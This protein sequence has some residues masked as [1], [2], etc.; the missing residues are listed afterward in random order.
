M[1]KTLLRSLLPAALLAVAVIIGVPTT[2]SAHAV[3]VDSTPRDGARLD[4]LPR[5]VVLRF[6]EPVQIA[7][8]AA[9]VITGSGERVDDG[10]PQL[11]DQGHTVI[12]GLRRDPIGHPASY[13]VSWQVVSADSHPVNG[14]LRFGVGR[15]P[16]PAP[17]GGSGGRSAAIIAG[18][19]TGLGYA[20]LVAALGSLAAGLLLWPSA[21]RSRRLIPLIIGGTAAIVAGGIVELATEAVELESLAAVLSGVGRLLIPRMIIAL[22][23]LPLSLEL[24]T[25]ARNRVRSNGWLLG[26]WGAVAVGLVVII[27]AHGHA[28]TGSDRLLTLVATTGHLIGMS[29][30]LGGLSVLIL[31]VLPRLRAHPAAAGRTI[32]G[33]SRFAFGC[34]AILIISGELLAWRQI[35]PIEALW[36]T[37]FGVILLIKLGL[38]AVALV[39]GR[40]TSRYAGRVRSGARVRLLLGV[41]VATTVLI[42][43]AATV[44]SATPPARDTYG[45]PTTSVISYPTG[46]LQVSIDPTRRGPQQITVTAESASGDPARLAAL[47]GRLSSADAGVSAIDVHFVPSGDHWQSTDATAPLPGVWTLQLVARPPGAKAYVTALDY[48]VW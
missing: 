32:R 20:G 17:G 38:I 29:G 35:Q 40:L 23:L 22:A 44:L 6:D 5:Q 45:P 4:R 31:V 36:R 46:E 1:L 37:P 39:L 42:I 33:W 18:F 41:E 12:I 47:S 48:R 9:R 11:T 26:V 28:L 43:A 16:A 21:L 13:L 8:D 30:W 27:A 25:R 3:L 7:P 14:S 34:V 15:E 24:L 19:G 10:D 2:A